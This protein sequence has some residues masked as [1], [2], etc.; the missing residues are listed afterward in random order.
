MP[1]TDSLPR[2]ARRR[3]LSPLAMLAALLLA[4]VFIPAARAQSGPPAYQLQYLGPGSP[5]AINNS[6]TVAGAR[7]N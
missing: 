6:G 4:L 7:L 5:A 1:T 2:N 3:R